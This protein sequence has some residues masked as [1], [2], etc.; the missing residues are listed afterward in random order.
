MYFALIMLKRISPSDPADPA[1]PIAPAAQPTQLTPAELVVPNVAIESLE[2]EPEPPI[3]TSSKSKPSSS[4]KGTKEI[5]I[6]SYFCTFFIFMLMVFISEQCLIFCVCLLTSLALYV[7][8][9]EK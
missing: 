6:F 2:A 3:A 1:I 7:K 9:G 5:V 8:K 4:K